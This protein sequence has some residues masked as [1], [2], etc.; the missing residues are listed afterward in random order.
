MTLECIGFYA[1]VRDDG[2]HEPLTSLPEPGAESITRLIAVDLAEE[3]RVEEHAK[4]HDQDEHAH[5]PQVKAEQADST[6]LRTAPGLYHLSVW[7][8]EP[9]MLDSQ[10]CCAYQEELEQAQ[11]GQVQR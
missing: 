9:R 10:H 11:I 2:Q 3:H 1:T 4:T 8:T 7:S 6:N 5:K